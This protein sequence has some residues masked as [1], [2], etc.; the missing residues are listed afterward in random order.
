MEKE[1]GETVEAKK[2]G[3]KSRIDS[4]EYW[5]RQNR[6]VLLRLKEEIAEKYRQMGLDEG[7]MAVCYA[8]QN[9]V[10]T[11]YSFSLNYHFLVA[12]GRKK[13]NVHIWFAIPIFLP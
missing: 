1:T 12:A 7:E 11:E 3:Q 6:F 10:G 5:E 9:L 4:V 2:F 13:A 8:S